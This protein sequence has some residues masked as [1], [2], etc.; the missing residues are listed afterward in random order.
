M[1]AQKSGTKPKNYFKTMLSI[2]IPTLNEEKFLP[3]LLD[4]IQ[5]Q[6][7]KI[8]HKII[9]ADAQSRD[10]TVEIAKSYGCK[11]VKGGLPAKGRNEGAKVAQGDLFLF[12]DADVILPK[13]FFEKVFQEFKERNLDIATFILYPQSSKKT[14][15]LLFNIFYNWPILVF[16]KVLSHAS[17]AIL[18][19]KDVF[20]KL[21]G[22]DEEI[23]F[24]EDHSF[25]RKAKKIGNFGILRSVRILSSLRRLEK[26]GWVLTY[27]KYVLAEIYTLLLGDIKRDIFNYKFG[28]F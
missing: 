4:S 9:I 11:I 28:D 22:F 2:I 14:K 12:L 18:V 24:A 17:Q 20:Q 23:K 5:K 27:L 25:V 26:E 6:D 13:N 8:E 7:F 21:G 10:K 1:I 19:K 3:F 15:K 16:E